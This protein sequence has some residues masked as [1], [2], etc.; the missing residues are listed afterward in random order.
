MSELPPAFSS[1]WQAVFFALLAGLV[2]FYFKGLPLSA[3]KLHL[4]YQSF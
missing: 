2:L 1:W 3:L 4:V